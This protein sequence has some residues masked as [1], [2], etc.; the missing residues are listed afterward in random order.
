MTRA[1]SEQGRARPT[2]AEQYTKTPPEKS[3]RRFFFFLMIPWQLG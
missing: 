1:G 2:H 3:R